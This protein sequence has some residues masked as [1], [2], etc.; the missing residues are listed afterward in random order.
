MILLFI[1]MYVICRS[2][3]PYG[4]YGSRRPYFYRRWGLFGPRFF[5]AGMFMDYRNPWMRRPSPFNRLWFWG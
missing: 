3:R 1:I 2:L 5:R 4:F